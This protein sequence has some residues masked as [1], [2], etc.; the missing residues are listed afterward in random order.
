MLYCFKMKSSTNSIGQL[1]ER[2]SALHRSMLRRFAAEEKLQ[3]VHVEIIQYLASCNR[4]SDTTQALSDYL[5]QTKGSISQ[6]LD[7]LENESYLSRVQDIKDK[8]YFHLRLSSKGKLIAERLKTALDFHDGKAPVSDPQLEK[9]L[10]ALQKKNDLKGFGICGSCK[11]NQKNIKGS[12]VCGLTKERLSTEDTE[13][14]CR[15]HEAS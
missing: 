8:R 11:F 9:I 7:Y 6:S 2:L 4:Y 15:E 12:F 10:S 14:I 13:K 1:L 3:L 5:G